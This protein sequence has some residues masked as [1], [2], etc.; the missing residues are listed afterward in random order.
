LSTKKITQYF[1]KVSFAI[2]ICRI[3]GYL[4][5]MFVAKFFGAGLYAD[6]FYA[7]YRIPNLFRRLLGEG[8]LSASFVP[9]FTEYLTTRGN[10]LK[11]KKETQ[12]LLDVVFTT[13]FL[14]L[15]SLAILGI[16]FAPEITKIVAWGFEISPKKLELTIT[17]VRIMFPY[18]LLICLAAL[19]LGTLNALHIFFLPAL[20]PLNLDFAEI[21]YILLIAGYL[22]S[23]IKGLAVAVVIGGLGQFAFQLPLLFKH[24][25]H[26]R[27]KINFRHPGLRKILCLMLPAMIGFSVEQINS[28]VDTLCG[29]FLKEGSVTALYYSNRLMQLPLALFGIA[30][31]TVSLPLM[32]KSVSEKNF[33]ELKE[34][35][36]LSLRTVFFIIIPA[37]VGLMILAQPIVR[38]LFER[39]AFTAEATKLTSQALF[40]YALGTFAYA[41]TKIV[42]VV[43]Y[44]LQDT[45]TPLKIAILALSLNIVLN[46]YLMVP[47]GVGGLALATAI[48]STVNLTVLLVILRLRIGKLGLRRIIETTKRTL[49]ATAVMGT[50]CYLLA[51]HLFQWST[52]L[53]VIIPCTIGV[54][55]YFLIAHFLK[56]EESKP[57]LAVLQKEEEVITSIGES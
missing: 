53:S 3:F 35:L 51:Y 6:A 10:H 1:S 16:L 29:S 30:M 38:L 28:F 40:Y 41:G 49:L 25:W 11:S 54:I 12:D 47:L 8:A 17:L 37:S 32:S 55:V 20:S 45:K 26:L 33:V 42:A 31:A 57:L 39:G 50:V 9:V 43:F 52:F 22:V 2:L 24:G 23:P 4:R 21:I 5:D 18:L 14:I 7:A 27:F 19:L 44:S 56:I 15:S 46:L 34:T 13:L 36:S 48:S